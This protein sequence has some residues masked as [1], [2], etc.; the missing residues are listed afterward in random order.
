[1]PSAKNTTNRVWQPGMCSIN[2]QALKFS[3]IIK[4]ITMTSRQ[5][6]KLNMYNATATFLVDNAAITATLPAFPAAVTALN[7]QIASIEAAAQTEA[8]VISGIT[9]NKNDLKKSLAQLATTNAAA[10]FAFASASGDAVLKEK[11]RYSYSDLYK[12]KDDELSIICQNLHA[13]ENAVLASLAPYGVTAATLTTFQTM[14]TDYSTEVPAPRNAASTRA[15]ARQQ[16]ND[17]FDETDELLKEQVDKLAVQFKVSEPE[18]YNAY[19][20]NRVILDAAQ[21]ATKVEG[22][23]KQFESA[24][25]I[26]GV[27]VD[28]EGTTYS[29]SSDVNGDYSL[30]IP[31]PGTYNIIFKHVAFKE[32]VMKDI[33][34]TLGQST[35]LN[36]EMEKI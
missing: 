19:K 30:K 4:L 33:V 2:S 11:A 8:E 28:A 7:N 10:L 22:N 20:S 17:L 1:M 14:I 3:L 26:A 29:T 18:F 31:V 6:S 35:K 25:P 9:V 15:A 32:V 12:L 5:E 36:V 13:E 27:Q 24:N 34:V 21:S 16:L 23:I